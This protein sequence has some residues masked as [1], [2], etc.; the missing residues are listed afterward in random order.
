[1]HEMSIAGVLY[2]RILMWDV[3]HCSARKLVCFELKELDACNFL[4]ELI[5][6]IIIWHGFHVQQMLYEKT[7]FSHEHHFNLGKF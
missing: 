6:T 1:M 4:L 3:S 7:I 5:F 2:M